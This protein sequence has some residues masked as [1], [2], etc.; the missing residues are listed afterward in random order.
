MAALATSQY[1]VD[2]VNIFWAFFGTN[3][4][5]ARILFLHDVTRPIFAAKHSI[6]F[7]M[8]VVGDGIVVCLGNIF[9]WY[10]VV[11]YGINNII[12]DLP[13]LCCM[14]T[15][16]VGCGITLALFPWFRR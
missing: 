14:G 7:T 15:Q 3:D 5:Q 1:V 16:V 9:A 11:E 10:R 6:F 2:T 12:A 13:C 4:R 8:M